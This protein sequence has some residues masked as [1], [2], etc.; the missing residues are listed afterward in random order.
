MNRAPLLKFSLNLQKLVI[1]EILAHPITLIDVATEASFPSR[2][3][4][5]VVESKRVKSARRSHLNRVDQ[6]KLW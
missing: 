4:A 2:G 1:S 3:A 5:S 6:G